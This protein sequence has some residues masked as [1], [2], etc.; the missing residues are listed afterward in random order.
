MRIKDYFTVLSVA[1]S[2]GLLLSIVCYFV[3]QDKYSSTE[4]SFWIS[5]FG[6]GILC[7]PIGYITAKSTSNCNQC[8]KAFVI[9]NN[10]QTDI[11]NFVKYK[12]ESVTENGSTYTKNVPY[13]VRRYYQHKKCDNCGHESKSEEKTESKA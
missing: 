12:N 10:G 3:W 11:E 4:N 2:L 13:N 5:W 1:L 6:I 7:L 8:G 9:S